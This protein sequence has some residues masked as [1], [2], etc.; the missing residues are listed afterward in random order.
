MHVTTAQLTKVL[1]LYE[2]RHP[3]AEISLWVGTKADETAHRVTVRFREWV[4]GVKYRETDYVLLQ[5]G[6]IKPKPRDS[7]LAYPV[8][9]GS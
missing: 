6:T 5:N 9:L 8:R 4:D 1:K 3:E 7:F 2:E